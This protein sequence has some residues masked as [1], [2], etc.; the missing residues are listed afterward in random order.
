MIEEVE[1][2]QMSNVS[3]D[4]RHYEIKAKTENIASRAQ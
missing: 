1:D 4:A 3:K 2:I